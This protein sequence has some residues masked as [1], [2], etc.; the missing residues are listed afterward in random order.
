MR[1]SRDVA[2][3]IHFLLDECFP[4]LIRDSRWFVWLPFRLLFGD[5][6]EVFLGF[7]ERAPQ[8]S[9]AEFRDVYAQVAP[10][11]IQRE[12]DLN[13]A[14]AEAIEANL[15]GGSVLDAG[16]GRGWLARRLAA[17]GDVHVHAI[18]IHVD[19]ALR[20]AEPG[21][22]WVEGSVEALPFP[23]G[24]FDTVICAHTLEHVQD[25]PKALAE[26]RRVARQ[27]LIVVVPKQRPY[28]YTFDLHLHFFP[29]RSSVIVGLGRRSGLRECTDCGGDWLFVEDTAER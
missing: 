18:D 19:P 26:L 21:I 17:R 27:R 10:V 20:E 22:G 4:P 8:L 28:R 13:T 2:L 6:A 3:W 25:L 7:K 11:L 9:P 15:V 12:T 16:A 1:L 14:C 29:T 23:D 24:A 5:R